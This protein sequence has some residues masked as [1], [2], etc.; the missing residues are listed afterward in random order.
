MRQPLNQ[1]NRPSRETQNDLECLRHQGREN[2]TVLVAGKNIKVTSGH[3]GLRSQMARCVKV[4]GGKQRGKGPEVS[5]LTPDWQDAKERCS[6]RVA[7]PVMRSE[8]FL[9]PSGGVLGWDRVR[10]RSR[11]LA[12]AVP[13][14]FAAKVPRWACLAVVSLP[15]VA[16][17]AMRTWWRISCG[18]RGA[19]GAC[20]LFRT[21]YTVDLRGRRG[22]RACRCCSTCASRGT[23]GDLCDVA[24]PPASFC[25]AGAG[26][27]VPGAIAGLRGPVRQIGCAH[28]SKWARQCEIV[29]G[30]RR[31]ESAVLSMCA[32]GGRF[33]ITQWEADAAGWSMMLCV[34]KH[35]GRL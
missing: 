19:L 21:C 23:H 26:N 7:I 35:S 9:F 15:N 6:R 17:V 3:L 32:R 2:E 20:W 27:R 4:S 31:R 28:A 1:R 14:G 18:R 33:V 12:S 13:L 30:G 16:I 8:E 25:V 11:K 29:A 24:S 22:D 34:T 10:E 5:F